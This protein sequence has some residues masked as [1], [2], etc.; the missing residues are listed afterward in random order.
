[1]PT[2][3]V[4]GVTGFVGSHVARRLN[5]CG[6]TPRIL[7]RPTSN[8]SNLADLQVEVV[9]GDLGDPASLR[10]ALY[11][12]EQLYH[13]AGYVSPRPSERARMMISNATGAANLFDAAIVAGVSRIVYLGSV[14]ALGASNTPRIWREGDPYNLGGMG[15]GYFDSKRAGQ[16]VVDERIRLGAPVVSVYPAYCL[17]PGDIYLSSSKLVTTFVQGKLPFYTEAGMGFLDVRDVAEAMVLAME[18]GRIGGRYFLSGHNL[19]YRQFFDTLATMAG[20]KPPRFKMPLPV[21]RLLCSV[22][23]PLTDGATLSR[24][25]YMALALYYWYDNSLAEKE[26]SWTYRSVEDMLRDSLAW[27]RQ[28][29][30]I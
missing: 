21:L 12:V 4:T 8:R 20:M 25:L 9:E 30:H 1:M 18:R 7:V 28:A 17:G 16:K 2:V 3:L 13:V 6:I 10:A 26:L 22:A 19:T 5:Q 24:S 29:G 15:I 27:L 14:T 23:E 11:G